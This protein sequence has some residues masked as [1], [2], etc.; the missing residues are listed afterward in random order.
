MTDTAPIQKAVQVIR[1]VASGTF[2]DGF[3]HAGNLAYLSMLAIFPF[4][5]LGA[6]L[7]DMIGG[8]AN[9]EAMVEAVAQALP[10]SVAA[11]IVP[12]AEDVI[13]AR[14]GWLLW[15]GAAVGPGCLAARGAFPTTEVVG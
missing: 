5:I 9:A 1:R 8:R 2:N 13:Y 7:F 4:F 10:N 6:A 12:V 3:I 11:V 15:L 14:S